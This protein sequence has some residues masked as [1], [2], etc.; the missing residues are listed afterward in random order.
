[1]F[2]VNKIA[3]SINT[4]NLAKTAHVKNGASAQPLKSKLHERIPYEK[5]PRA[6]L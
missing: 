2:Y 4:S 1:M 5:S 3:Y 6:Q